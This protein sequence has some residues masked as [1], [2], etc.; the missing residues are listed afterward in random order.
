MKKDED[1]A[2]WDHGYIEYYKKAMAKSTK[3]NLTKLLSVRIKF[4]EALRDFY[5]QSLRHI[6]HLIQI[7]EKP[8]LE[9]KEARCEIYKISLS[10]RAHGK[11]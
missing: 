8:N 2:Q 5:T 9:L 3:P 4:Y 6:N 11:S 7:D 1:P 10:F